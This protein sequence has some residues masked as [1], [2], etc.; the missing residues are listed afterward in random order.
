MKITIE[1]YIFEL[2]WVL[3]FSFNKQLLLFGTNSPQKRTLADKNRKKNEHHHRIL[4]VQIS[5]GNKF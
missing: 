4:L 5:L 2:V 1:F 3:N